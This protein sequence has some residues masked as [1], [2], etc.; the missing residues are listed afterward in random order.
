MNVPELEKIS[1]YIE[2]ASGGIFNLIKK[3][4]Q[5]DKIVIS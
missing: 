2:E 1:K 4:T 3:H 5:N